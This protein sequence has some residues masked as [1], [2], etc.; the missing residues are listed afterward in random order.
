MS[1]PK[2][3]EMTMPFDAQPEPKTNSQSKRTM[4]DVLTDLQKKEGKWKEYKRREMIGDVRSLADADKLGQPLEMIEADADVL[5]ARLEHLGWSAVGLNEG[6]W[7]NWKSNI[8][9]AIL[10]T[11]INRR[12]EGAR[13]D[14]YP[15]AWYA[16]F[17]AIEEAI[18]KGEEKEFRRVSLRTIA[19]Q[20]IKMGI[21]SP[22]G[23]TQAVVDA[24]Y[25]DYFAL[26]GRI[27]SALGVRVKKRT[28]HFETAIV[29]WNKSWRQQ[30]QKPWFAALPCVD[31]E[32]IGK[33]KRDLYIQFDKMHPDLVRDI[34]GAIASISGSDKPKGRRSSRLD[35]GTPDIPDGRLD[36]KGKR[37][38]NLGTDA[39][40]GLEVAARAIITA[41][42]KK[43]GWDLADIRSLKSLM[44]F[45][46]AVDAFD[47]FYDRSTARGVDPKEM[48]SYSTFAR[49]V[50]RF[51]VWAK[52]PEKDLDDLYENHIYHKAVQGKSRKLTPSRRKMLRQFTQ[53]SAIERWFEMPGK[54]WERAEAARGRAQKK[55]RPIPESAIADIECAAALAIVGG[56]MPLRC[57]NVTWIRHKGPY[58]T[59]FLPTNSRDSGYISIPGS[60]VKNGADL[61]AELDD[62][63]LM[64]I[65]GYL[66]LGYRN[67][68]FHWN[69]EADRNT[70]FLFPGCVSA[71]IR[72]KFYWPGART[73]GCISRGVAARF[74]EVGLEVEFHLGRHIVA[75]L[76]LDHDDGLL[77]TVA[78]LLG[79][80]V[81]TVKAYY[82]DGDTGRASNIL[83]DIIV[84]RMR[85]MKSKWTRDIAHMKK[86]K[87][88][89]KKARVAARG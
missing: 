36:C 43:G 7:K 39:I 21:D 41:A 50:G 82:I 80:L 70:D 46:A 25:V 12:T 9:W 68:F 69:P 19:S 48:T 56:V 29:E 87:E 54:L 65:S 52:L 84:A 61:W 74:A 81:S 37:R 51:A 85:A 30:N 14:A 24:L 58:Q 49:N 33:P 62:Q 66:T 11:G 78:D 60:E 22:A 8:K 79:D 57:A 64:I 20:A 77:G 55:G 76:M 67:D 3:M 6:R 4:A 1:E 31:L 72:N 73:L 38:G 44:S 13:R 34:K 40:A 63:S 32:R 10:G 23:V 88:D 26:H 27:E 2:L 42:V 17:T 18:D 5:I 35:G 28:R 53:E 71:E 59:L 89:M 16:L 83:K 15:P 75:K 47:Q 45:D 86:A